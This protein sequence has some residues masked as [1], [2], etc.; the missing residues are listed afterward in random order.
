MYECERCTYKTPDRSN[1]KKHLLKKKP[2]PGVKSQVSM[3]EMLEKFNKRDGDYC[4][5]ECEKKYTSR[6]GLYLHQKSVHQDTTSIEKKK[7][8]SESDKIKKLEDHIKRLEEAMKELSQ[9][10]QKTCETV[11]ITNNIQ[12]NITINIKD[13]DSEN[14]EAISEQNLKSYI[15]D[16]ELECIVRDLHMNEE[17]PENFNVRMKNVNRKLM[18]Y[19]SEGKWKVEEMDQMLLD[20]IHQ[21]RRI[22]HQ[23]YHGNMK[24]RE[25]IT[26]YTMKIK[27]KLKS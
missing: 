11:N 12:N 3:Q 22:A 2:C 18:E 23:Y 14:K 27:K 13:W 26:P 21:S 24:Q 8:E 20:V 5:S 9:D 1:F 17:Y 15:K 19:Y 10:S 6:Q 4:C 16:K 25:E 7:P